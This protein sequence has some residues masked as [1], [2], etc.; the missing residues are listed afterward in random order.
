MDRDAPEY[1]DA[2]APL[3]ATGVRLLAITDSEQLP[4]GSE[5]ATVALGAPD[6]LVQALPALPEICWVQSTWAGVT[7]FLPWA[8][9]GGILTGVKDVFGGQM[10]EY[11]MAGLLER[12]IDLPGRRATQA[13]GE[14]H[15]SPTATLA[16]RTLGIMGTGSIG[17][18][19][20]R[21]AEAFG[22]RPIGYSRSGTSR[23]PFQAVFPADQL[24]GFLAASDDVVGVLP[25][26]PETQGLLDA[27]AFAAMRPD[28]LFINVGRGTLVDDQALVL[29]LERQQIGAALLD[30][31]H[32][33]PLPASHPFWTCPR[34]TLTAH[35]AARSWP[36]D[37]AALFMENLA[38][39]R[40]GEA[41][42]H[43]I[44][45]LLGY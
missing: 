29:A 21:R 28:A 35:V 13:R 39:Y 8:R 14:W 20:A 44:D 6:L 31:F 25:D 40:S 16:G 30:V 19:I 26:T 5:D 1:L 7:P 23:P 43:P 38:R 12:A 10:A 37:L 22:M 17:A 11:V 18:E 45:P 3:E 34:L 33:E 32:E 15:A 2:L 41:L 42:L 9:A 4:E 27:N 36:A 24:H